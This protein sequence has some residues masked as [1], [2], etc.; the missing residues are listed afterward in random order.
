[1]A[2]KIVTDSTS[3]IPKDLCKTYDISIV[4]LN[5]I[6]NGVS[7]RES[8]VSHHTFYTELSHSATLPTSSQPTP[9]EMLA[10]FENIIQQ[11]HSVLGIFLSSEMSG[12]YSSAHLIRSMLLEKYPEA[13]IEIFD[14][15]TNCMQ[16]GFIALEAARLACAEK[17]MSEIIEHCHLVRQHSRFIFTPEVLTYLQKGGR[18]GGASALVGQF[19]Q[20]KPILT[21]NPSG[22]TDVYT[23]VRTKK[24][25]IAKLIE[26]LLEDIGS[27]EHL[28]G[29]IV[30]HIDCEQEGLALAKALE[31]RL[32][33]SVSIESIGPV[34][35]SHVG[36]GSIGIAYHYK[37]H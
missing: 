30:H 22:K 28:E 2:I 23:K 29:L 3:Y 4:S 20:I 12:T 8:D 24:K 32:N 33:R 16:M 10:T 17:S 27:P 14:S 1:M 19:L 34:I 36:P 18:I 5:V 35:G 37:P 7:Q 11:G 31:E 15:L 26:I 13:H 9:E 21:V 6:L 25:A